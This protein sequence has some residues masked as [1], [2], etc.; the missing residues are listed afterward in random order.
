M[1]GRTRPTHSLHRARKE[2]PPL[3]ECGCGLAVKTRRSGIWSRWL[4]GHHL[5]G[6]AAQPYLVPREW[7]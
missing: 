6:R 4:P 7:T 2:L 5:R 1:S 3:C